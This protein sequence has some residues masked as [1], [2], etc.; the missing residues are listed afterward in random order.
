MRFTVET[1]NV[2]K[3]FHNIGYPANVTNLQIKKEEYNLGVG[4]EWEWSGI[5]SGSGRE[6]ESE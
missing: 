6:R 4:V 2:F 1:F 3:N 5:G